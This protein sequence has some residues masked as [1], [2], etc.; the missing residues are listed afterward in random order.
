MI[1][2]SFILLTEEDS[3]VNDYVHLVNNVATHVSSYVPVQQP[4]Q[5][6]VPGVLKDAF[7]MLH[8]FLLLLLQN[9]LDPFL[10]PVQV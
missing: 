7:V 3:F 4:P 10:I 2:F 9:I 1:V 6:E 8:Y 5:P